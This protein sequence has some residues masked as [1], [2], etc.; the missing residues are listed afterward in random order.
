MKEAEWTWCLCCDDLDEKFLN[1][2]LEGINLRP[3]L[4]EFV[5]RDGRCNHRP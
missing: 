5:D 3:K 2:N 4:R 1:R